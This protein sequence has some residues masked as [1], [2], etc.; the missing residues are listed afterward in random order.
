VFDAPRDD[1]APARDG[2]DFALL[3][4]MGDTKNLV[5]REA[6]AKIKDIADNEIAM[7]C[8]FTRDRAMEARPMGTQRIASDGTVWFFS[9][10]DSA[11]N[12]QILANPAVQLIYMVSG[13]SEY[14]S[15]DG[16]ASISHDQAKIDELWNGLAKA[17]F[18]EGK[19]DPDLTLI[20]VTL[21]GGHYWDTK[22]GKMISLAKL[23]IAAVTG[24]PRE[25]GIEG[26][27]K[28]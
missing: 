9:R 20:T 5:S 27:L 6:V 23:A 7:L 21:L 18:P 14:L 25:H 19:D 1:A 3:T 13:K 26:A 22:N 16:T 4:G 15:L 24:K 17:W 2:Q 28:V 8:T 11:V 12:Q 10:K